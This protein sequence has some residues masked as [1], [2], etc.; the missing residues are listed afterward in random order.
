MIIDAQ[1]DVHLIIPLKD[2]VYILMGERT[3]DSIILANNDRVYEKESL[4]NLE[5]IE[6]SYLRAGYHWYPVAVQSAKN[7]DLEVM[8]YLANS[9]LQLMPEEISQLILQF[10]DTKNDYPNWDF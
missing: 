2:S 10:E 3:G 4:I 6:D 8:W 9:G 1:Y 5:V 7:P